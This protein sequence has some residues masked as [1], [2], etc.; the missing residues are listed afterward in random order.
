MNLRRPLAWLGAVFLV[1]VP[2]RAEQAEQVAELARPLI[3]KKVIVGCVIGVL[4]GEQKQVHA[5]GDVALGSGQT[6]DGGT[7]YEIGSVT[8]AFT[9]TL[10]ADM[11]LRGEVTLD[12]PI[13]DYLPAGTTPPEV[14][15]R[16]ITLA[17]LAAHTSGLPKVPDNLA[18]A[19]P[20]NP[21]A[22]YDAKRMY[23]FLAGYKP[24]KPPG[25]YEYSNYGA[26][27][28]GSLLA[29]RAGKSYEQLVVERITKPLAM[30]DTKIQLT[31]ADRARLAPPYDGSLQP[32]KNWDVTALAGAGAIRSTA[33]DCLKLLEAAL[34]SDAELEKLPADK[35]AVVRALRLAWTPRHGKPGEMGVG[36]GWHIHPDG[37]TRWHNGQTG[38][39]S[40]CVYAVPGRRLAVVVLAN[41]ASDLV[42]ELAKKITTSLLG[43]EVEPVQVNTGADVDAAVLDRLVGKYD[44]LPTFAIN[45][46]VENDRLFAQATGQGKLEL[47]AVSPTRFRCKAVDAEISFVEERGKVV[48]LILHQ[49][50]QDKPGIKAVGDAVLKKYV[51]KYDLAP[52][53]A[54]NITLEDDH[55]IAQATGQGKLELSAVSPTRFRAKEVDAEISFVEKRGQVVGLVLHQNGADTPGKKTAGGPPNERRTVK[56]APAVL[57]TYVGKYE[58]A[59]AFAIDVTAEGDRLFVQ[60]SGQGK[61]ELFATTPVRFFSKDVDAEVGFV[62][63]RGKVVALI[64]RQGGVDQRGNKKN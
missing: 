64:L 56:V 49:N 58:L 8:K 24:P 4:D 48:S 41:T 11:A 57:K 60:A 3:D 62:K 27:L 13:A 2:C 26:G 15:Y 29:E 54:I 50:G 18:P 37:V 38:G 31:A 44:L 59:P 40:S 20:A 33:D 36:L 22:D 14:N 52:Q 7:I 42:D 10:L 25:E 28:L 6:P 9:G 19:D 21:Y 5:F 12:A 61:L 53:F 16:P 46:T 35:G 63:K 45:I 43:A 30:N 39:Y 51:G 55:L 17:D 1:A 34:T 32:N 23:A 47:E